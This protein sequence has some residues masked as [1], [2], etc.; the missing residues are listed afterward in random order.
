MPRPKK[1]KPNHA[2]GLYEVKITIGKGLDGK[3]QRKSF[4]SSVSKEDARRMAEQWKIEKEVANR[5][6]IGHV[7][8][9][10][11]FS[12]WADYWLEV[13]KKPNVTA[14]TYEGTYK[15]FVEKHLKPYFGQTELSMIRPADIQRFYAEKKSLSASTLHKMSLCLNGIFETAIDNDLCY[16]NPARMADYT[17]A[18]NPKEKQA[19][20]EEQYHAIC[21]ISRKVMPSVVLLLETGL[22]CG[23]LCGLKWKDISDG[24]IHVSRSIAVDKEN[25][26]T[27]RPPKWN[28]YR[29]IPLSPKAKNALRRLK[30][31][32]EFV[33][34]AKPG[35]PYTPRRWAKILLAYM[36]HIHGEHPEIPILSAH[37]LRHSYGT[38]LRRRGID[39]YT[40]QKVMGHKDIN[41]T[42]QTYVHSEID[43]LKKALG[44]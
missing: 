39:I 40:I 42:A 31:D 13:Y 32:D 20:T 8:K 18:Q 27:V 2:G 26:Y 9:R 1:E 3:L 14:N 36:E 43:T 33:M 16:K 28:S 41:I 24:I 44:L 25:G 35:T 12:S 38:R 30:N 23:E 17:S 37:E 4:Y 10:K 22:R 7:D 15:L 21:R 34:P 19:Y 6:G 29:A 11:D 5:S